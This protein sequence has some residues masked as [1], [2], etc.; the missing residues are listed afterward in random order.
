MFSTVKLYLTENP[1]KKLIFSTVYNGKCIGN[2]CNINVAIT[3]K[4]KFQK[5]AINNS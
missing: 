4:I 3:N 5:N 1:N 2:G